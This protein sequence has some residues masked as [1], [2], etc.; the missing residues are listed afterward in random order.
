MYIVEYLYMYISLLLHILFSTVI[1][2]TIIPVKF[3]TILCINSPS[4]EN[5][6]DVLR[7]HARF[8][9]LLY[10]SLLFS[11]EDGNLYTCQPNT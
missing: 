2:L 4:L 6:N 9:A 8:F 11:V 5:S 10:L 7:L 1:E 3:L